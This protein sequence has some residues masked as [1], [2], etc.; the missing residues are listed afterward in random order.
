MLA[1]V[2][3]SAA[4]G[5]FPQWNCGCEQCQAVRAERGGARSRTTSSIALTVGD[6]EWY[7][8]G[9][10][11]H[12]G[13][14]LAAVPA[15]WPVP[16]SRPVPISGV[17]LTD[18]ELDHTLGLLALRQASELDV[19]ATH[20]VRALLERSGLAAVLAGYLTL[21]WHEVVPGQPFD[22]PPPT[23]G[24]PPRLRCEAFALGA[25]R[26]PRYAA[27]DWCDE[28]ARGACVVG[29]RVLDLVS[30]SRA[31]L[32]PVAPRVLTAAE[33]EGA[34]VVVLDGTFWSDDELGDPGRRAVDL[35]HVPMAG[36]D[37]SLAWTRQW[38]GS[39]SRPARVVYTHLN[40]TNPV[41]TEGPERQAVLAAGAELAH[42]D[43]E[44]DL[45]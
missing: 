21:R 22:L 1:R 4:G 41:L 36:T 44:I 23:A 28:A 18:A 29:Y 7:L 37:G 3:G 12:L 45:C 13:V 20:G 42:D 17:I 26:L 5:G 30:G 38:R 32:A 6:G 11:E 25:G 9:A 15:L 40:N 39:T 35:G 10:G 19:Y 24:R 31:V 43:M 34:D 27:V 14:Q 8:W 2:L 33:V 16:R